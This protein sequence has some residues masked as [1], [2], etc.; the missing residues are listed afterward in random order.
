MVSIKLDG[1][2][3]KQAWNIMKSSNETNVIFIKMALFNITDSFDKRQQWLLKSYK[4]SVGQKNLE[5]I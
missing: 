1:I 5:D 3:S 2:T 4:D